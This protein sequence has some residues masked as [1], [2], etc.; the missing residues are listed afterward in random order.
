MPFSDNDIASMFPSNDNN[1]GAAAVK[2]AL[3]SKTNLSPP[4]NA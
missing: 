1:R 4:Q 3:D 2:S